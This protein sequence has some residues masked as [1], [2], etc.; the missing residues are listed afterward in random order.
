M[1][2]FNKYDLLFLRSFFLYYV[3][4]SRKQKID[5]VDEKLILNW[6]LN[7]GLNFVCGVI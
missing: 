7:R 4:V 2:E 3:L 1:C 5:F 6:L